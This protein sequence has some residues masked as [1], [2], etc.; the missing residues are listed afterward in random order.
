MAFE[1][2]SYQAEKTHDKMPS[3]GIIQPTMLPNVF[4]WYCTYTPWYFQNAMIFSCAN[5][6][7]DSIAH[8]ACQLSGTGS[9]KFWLEVGY[10]FLMPSYNTGKIHCQ[11]LS[12]FHHSYQLLKWPAWWDQE[13]SQTIIILYKRELL[14]RLF[15]KEKK[16]CLLNNF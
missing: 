11:N 7:P 16:W 5:V 8:Y 13:D 6:F 4:C 12:I 2:S 9:F 3:K 14:R 15:F 1:F 10:Q